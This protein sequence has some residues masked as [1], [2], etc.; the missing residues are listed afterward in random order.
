MTGIM[1]V[2]GD[3]PARG[4]AGNRSGARIFPPLVR[5]GE[6]RADRRPA[7]A[8]R[9]GL[10][11][12][13]PLWLA[14]G[15][16]AWLMLRIQVGLAVYG[17]L[18]LVVGL[19]AVLAGQ[20][21]RHAG[22]AGAWQLAD[23][24]RLLIFAVITVAAGFTLAG[25]RSE[26]VAAPILG[27]RY[28]GPVEGR[29]VDIDRSAQDRLRITLDQVV[30]R[31]LSPMR[32]PGKVRLSLMQ[33]EANLPPAGTR[34]MLT[35]HL[36]PPPAPA[37]PGGFDF[38][39][40][41]WFGGLG[42]VGYTRTPIMTVIPAAGRGGALITRIRL[43][44][45]HAI[46]DHIP[47]QSGAVAAA[48]TTGDRAGITT[49]TNEVMR[50]A[51]IYHIVAISGLHMS[52]LTGF[53]YA[54]LRF[55]A[56]G[57]QALGAFPGLAAHKFAAI[58]ALIAAGGYLVLSGGGPA[59]ERAF[60][61]VSIMLSAILFGRRAIS[62]RTVALAAVI[63]LAFMPESLSGAGFQMSFAATVALIIANDCTRG[64]GQQSRW[65][66]VILMVVLTTI[67]AELATGP[68][69]AAQFN[70]ISYYGLL[71]NVAV[72]PV[73]GFIVMPA[74]VL[75]GFLAPMGLA[76][77]ALWVMG[78]G[79]NWMLAVGEWVSGLHGAFTTIAAPPPAVLPMMGV[80]GVLLALT[81]W[82]R[83]G[84]SW[85]IPPRGWL[86]AAFLLLGLMVWVVMPRPVLLIGPE[87]D[88]VGLMTG[89]GR[90]PSKDAGGAFTVRS[91]LESDGD[92]A[93]QAEAA[94]RIAWT[95][96]RN[97]RQAA[98]PWG[99][100]IHHLTGKGAAERAVDHC[101]PGHLLVLDDAAP[102][103]LTGCE[104]I[105]LPRLRDTG[106]WAFDAKGRARQANR[107][108]GPRPWV[109]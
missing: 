75:A 65:R 12:W 94:A 97:A 33:D 99:G 73:I 47:G 42:A 28:Y 80:G 53:L 96:P 13:L 51:N 7:V 41:A 31:D 106:A 89:A 84:L 40:H 82:R 21:I 79:I 39:R 2:A 66:R 29:L 36:G 69:A 17:G 24:L 45:S 64:F 46:Q 14:V 10:L 109:Q 62:L 30:L 49:H 3:A 102:S 19:F 38:R 9:S 52:L 101:R 35:G 107:L 78:A 15:I 4:N 88:A 59:T 20:I 54:C 26:W 34:I 43:Q 16:G 6:R 90:V 48:I 85:R 72:V 103:G 77:P 71:A 98:L 37:E 18:W 57:A 11:P 25:L 8:A 87:G 50:K 5:V 58:G 44:L 76:A 108:I 63:L 83:G 55:L 23:M 1:V 93:K 68:I 22:R 92:P 27:F 91:W 104:I 81:P 67:V 100:V 60:V 74:A 105:D 86:G 70:R 56:V 95:G 32:T 61:M